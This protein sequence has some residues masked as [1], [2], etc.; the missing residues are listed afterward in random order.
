MSLDLCKQVIR[1][2]NNLSHLEHLG[3]SGNKLT[4]CLQYFLPHSHLGMP[5]L[6]GLFLKEAAVSSRDVKHLSNLLQSSK[7]P[8]LHNLHLD[9]SLSLEEEDVAQ[10]IETCVKQSK[11]NFHLSLEDNSLSSTFVERWKRRCSRTHVKLYFDSSD[12]GHYG[13]TSTD[14]KVS[15]DFL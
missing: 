9:K 5:S 12:Y 15:I 1:E 8:Q 11:S 3:L 6:K 13:S 2:V 7:M 10:L 4:D 14:N